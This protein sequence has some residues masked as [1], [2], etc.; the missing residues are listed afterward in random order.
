MSNMNLKKVQY[1]HIKDK[2]EN[3]RREDKNEMNA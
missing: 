1:N 2:T 3:K